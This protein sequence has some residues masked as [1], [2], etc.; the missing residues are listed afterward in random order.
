MSPWPGAIFCSLTAFVV[1]SIVAVVV[2]RLR[3][4]RTDGQIARGMREAM[5]LGLLE[6]LH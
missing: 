4:K 2:G 6:D 3:D 5:R 1:V